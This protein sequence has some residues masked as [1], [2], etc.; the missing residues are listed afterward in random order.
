M[1]VWPSLLLPNWMP[2]FLRSC[3]ARPVLLVVLGILGGGGQ[4]PDR[5]RRPLL[6]DF[7][8][9]DSSVLYHLPPTPHPSLPLPVQPHVSQQPTYKR[10]LFS[11]SPRRPQPSA[12]LYQSYFR[13]PR[14]LMAIV[15]RPSF[16]PAFISLLTPPCSEVDYIMA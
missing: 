1:S 11:W 10:E 2:P 9:L 12:R 16:L 8:T 6:D 14:H 5:I 7:K 13:P 3:S 15:P 4:R